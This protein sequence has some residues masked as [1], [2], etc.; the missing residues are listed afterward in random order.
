MFK[1]DKVGISKFKHKI[2]YFAININQKIVA[3]K[4]YWLYMQFKHKITKF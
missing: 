2:S 4:I 3:R 1:L